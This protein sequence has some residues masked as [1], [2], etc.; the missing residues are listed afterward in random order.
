MEI[1]FLI[2]RDGK[3]CPVEVK[4]AALCPNFCGDELLH[5]C[6]KKHI[7]FPS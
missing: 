6:L 2:R 7:L 1:D 3:I 4:S 5:F